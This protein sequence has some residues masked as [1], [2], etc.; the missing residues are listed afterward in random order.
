[1][2][3]RD[4]LSARIADDGCGFD[5]REPDKAGMGLK[6]MQYR[7]QLIGAHLQVHSQPD[8]GVLVSCEVHLPL[9]RF[10]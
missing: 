1:M 2:H 7:A 4:V 8:S 3:H 5:S 9:G 6:S 10:D